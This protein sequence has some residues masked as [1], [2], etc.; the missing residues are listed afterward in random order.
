MIFREYGADVMDSF[1]PREIEGALEMHRRN[2]QRRTSRLRVR[3]GERD[4]QVLELTDEGFVI[5]ADGRPPL[6]G[7]ADIFRGDERVLRGLV[8]CAWAE[9]GLVRY[10]F[11]RDTAGGNVSP[12]YVPPVHAG[13]LGSPGAT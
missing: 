8:L 4:H 5:E 11:K 1:L 6:R 13:L 3:A 2:T 9:D 7:F 10:E 12:D